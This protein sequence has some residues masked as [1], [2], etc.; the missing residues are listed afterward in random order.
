MIEGA[1]KKFA[2]RNLTMRGLDGARSAGTLLPLRGNRHSHIRHPMPEFAGV[3]AIRSQ[4][5]MPVMVERPARIGGVVR[6]SWWLEK[7]KNR[8]WSPPIQFG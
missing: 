3:Q 7:A 1:N 6:V 5:N 4:I 8:I 2:H